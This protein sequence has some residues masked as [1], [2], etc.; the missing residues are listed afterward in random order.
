MSTLYVN[1]I[2]PDSGDTVNLSGSLTISGEITIGNS[3]SDIIDF[4]SVISSSLIPYVSGG[5]TISEH[6]LGSATAAWK[7]LFISSGSLI[8][9]DPQGEQETLSK[10]DIRSLKSGKSLSTT[11]SKQLVNKLDSTTYVRQS[12]AGKSWFY[13]SDVPILKVQTSSLDLG[14]PGNG[15][16]IRLTG[17]GSKQITGSLIASG[18]TTLT[19]SFESTG[20]FVVNDLL[21]LLANFGQTGIPTGSGQGGVAEGDINLDGQ[22][23]VSDMLLLLAGY[24]NANILTSNTTIPPNVNHQ[25]VGPTISINTGVTLSVSTGSFCSITL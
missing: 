2:Q 7:D 14:N 16:P 6:S 1:N 5:G 24:G 17:T 13:A 3:G 22:V 25:F 23:N 11:G 8:F 20:S 10:A 4:N 15:V 21:N 19:G 9:I 12:V 18:S